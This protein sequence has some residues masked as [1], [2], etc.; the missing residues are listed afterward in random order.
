[1]RLL[2][3]T[4]AEILTLS[5]AW[6]SMPNTGRLRFAQDFILD[7]RLARES[8]CTDLYNHVSI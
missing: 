8:H 2:Q 1:M 7:E 5:L 6:R 4:W 3:S